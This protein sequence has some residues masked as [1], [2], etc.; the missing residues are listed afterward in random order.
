MP[1]VRRLSSEHGAAETG[2]VTALHDLDLELA[3][4]LQAETRKR[5]R[6]KPAEIAA[7]PTHT[8]ERKPIEHPVYLR[9]RAA[10]S[11]FSTIDV[12]LHAAR[13]TLAVLNTG[14][15]A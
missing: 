1:E 12:D 2:G 6:R 3:D 8:L 9:V 4:T 5:K 13:V 10:C 7:F 11:D 15:A 14:K